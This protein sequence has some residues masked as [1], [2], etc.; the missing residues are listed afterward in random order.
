[1]GCNCKWGCN[2]WVVTRKSDGASVVEL[3]NPELVRKVNT[4]KY[5]AQCAGTY[6]AELNNKIKASA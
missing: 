1:M 6:L 2:S 5:M 3:Y 4:D